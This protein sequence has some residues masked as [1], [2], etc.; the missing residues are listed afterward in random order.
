MATLICFLFSAMMSLE[1]EGKG[2]WE[3]KGAKVGGVVGYGIAF[4]FV[5]LIFIPKAEGC[6]TIAI[7]MPSR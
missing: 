4:A 5:F 7:N 2:Y 6:C 3:L 1:L